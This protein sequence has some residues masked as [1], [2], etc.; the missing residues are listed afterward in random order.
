MRRNHQ[1]F[2]LYKLRENWKR[3]YSKR[4]IEPQFDEVGEGLSIFQPRSL[5]IFGRNIHLGQHVHIISSR[6]QP[7]SLSTWSSKQDQ[8]GIKIGDYCLLSP[9]V[10]ISSALEVTIEKNSMIA[11]EAYI[12][13]SDWHGVYNRLSLEKA[14]R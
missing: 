12:S 13:D 7:V 11:A 4:I 14:S 8:G 9:G 2:W 5:E 10:N 1:P 6:S 3:T